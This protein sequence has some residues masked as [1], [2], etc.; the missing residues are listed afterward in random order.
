MRWWC[1]SYFQ[2]LLYCLNTP[3]GSIIIL[4]HAICN[5]F[6]FALVLLVWCMCIGSKNVVSD[7]VLYDNLDVLLSEA[8]RCVAPVILIR[9]STLFTKKF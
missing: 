2:L 6:E 8:T 5:K 3:Q 7:S 9:D 4:H 1:L